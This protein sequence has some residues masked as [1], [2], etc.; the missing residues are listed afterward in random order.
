VAINI[1]IVFMTVVVITVMTTCHLVSHR[2]RR[3]APQCAIHLSNKLK[4]MLLG[5]CNFKLQIT[6]RVTLIFYVKEET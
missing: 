2:Q 6:M 5:W 3:I 1:V 4:H